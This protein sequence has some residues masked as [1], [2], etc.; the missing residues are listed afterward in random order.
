MS[1]TTKLPLSAVIF[2][3]T[4]LGVSDVPVFSDALKRKINTRPEVVHTA[5]LSKG[6]AHVLSTVCADSVRGQAAEFAQ[7]AEGDTGPSVIS[8][9]ETSDNFKA[10]LDPTTDN[11]QTQKDEQIKEILAHVP[12]TQQ[13][14]FSP[15]TPFVSPYAFLRED[16]EIFRHHDTT[17]KLHA[18][19]TAKRQEITVVHTPVITIA[20][21]S[22]TLCAHHTDSVIDTVFIPEIAQGRF[23]FTEEY[24][25][26]LRRSV[27]L[28]RLRLR[29]VHGAAPEYT[30]VASQTLIQT[31]EQS[32][33]LLERAIATAYQDVRTQMST[34]KQ[35]TTSWKTRVA[36]VRTH[37][38]QSA[39]PEVLSRLTETI[40]QT[41]AAIEVQLKHVLGVGFDLIA[42]LS[43]LQGI[44]SRVLLTGSI[45]IMLLTVGPMVILEAQS[46]KQRLVYSLTPKA[47]EVIQSPATTTS[48]TPSPTPT[49]I[50]VP[51]KQF[52]LQIPKIGADMRVI[53]N[54]DAGNEKEYTQALKKGVAHAAGT[55]LPGEQSHTKTIFIFGHS[56][57]GEW[58]ISRYNAL[59]Y[60]LKDLVLG[61]DIRLWFW[62]TA[63]DYKVT[64][65]KIV[66]ANDT[67]FL[68]PQTDKDQLILQTCWP[69]G[70]TWKR[71]LI[72]AERK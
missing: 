16:P 46:L 65:K 61:D 23:A 68:A 22:A 38:K 39:H 45:V 21:L 63:Y 3:R 19:L 26:A 67:S 31:I 18:Y 42:D 5:S 7:T 27:L 54:V 51:E 57:N 47:E 1:S 28:L 48:E 14:R 15:L 50:P 24:L 66:E 55:N 52:Q 62:G 71:L 35:W 37:E 10:P 70:T 69:P 41:I 30:A 58:N 53:A 4:K 60:S 12:T 34:G 13:V 8:I 2:D 56:T 49:A 29:D 9:T 32:I 43:T 72:F 64:E 59:F 20:P 17:H 11:S 44:A 40:R 25:Y 33:K 36:V 6:A